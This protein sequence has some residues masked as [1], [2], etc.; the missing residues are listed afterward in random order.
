M[1]GHV[2]FDKV[3]F[4]SKHNLIAFC[5]QQLHNCKTW[6]LNKIIRTQFKI[7]IRK[8][9]ILDLAHSDLCDLYVLCN[10]SK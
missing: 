5:S 8:S 2:N 1:L 10:R 9:I 4:M 7:V 6:I 3:S